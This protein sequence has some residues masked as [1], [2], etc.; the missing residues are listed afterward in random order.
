MNSSLPSLPLG[1]IAIVL[2]VLL[3]L[4]FRN[5]G[6]RDKDMPP[7][8]KTTLV[9][10]NALEFPTSFPHIKF[11]EWTR[12]YGDIFSLKIFDR[13]I[14]VVSSATA[15]KQILDIDGART[16]NRP[17]SKIAHRVTKG[18]SMFLENMENPVWKRGSQVI[19]NFLNRGSLEK[20]LRI[21]E[22]EISQ[23]MY[24]FLEDPKNFYRHVC[25]S[26][27]SAILTNIYGVRVAK[28][29]GSI[30]ETYFQGIKLFSE[31]LD[32]G[33]HPPVDLFW[34]LQYVPKRWAYWKRLADSTRA[35][36]DELYGSLFAQCELAVKQKNFT[37]CYMDSLI[38]N[39]AKS[40]MS[41][42]EII[43][44]GAV[45]MDGGVKT[46]ATFTHSLVLALINYPEFQRKAQE[47]IDTVVGPDRWPRLK[48]YENV[49]YIRAIVD[50]VIRFRT[51]APVAIPHVS[52]EEVRY[53]GYRIPKDSVI[54][55]NV[56]GIF[57]DP[58]FYDHPEE[59]RPERFLKTEFGTKPGVDMTGYRNNF[60]FGA[61]RRA[62]PGEAL[63]RQNMALTIM[64]FLWAFDFK[65]DDSGTGGY[66]L[67]TYERPG[68]ELAPKEFTC[69]VL[70][71]S[72]AKA[73]MIRNRMANVYGGAQE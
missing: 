53:K 69:D 27:A 25:R 2:L 3:F 9:L 52:T 1:G 38:S 11:L 6:T 14:I 43:G 22:D 63:A 42:D 23:C 71:R 18:W 26:T 29:E 24:N 64:N 60:T 12:Q 5:V 35:I 15:V 44:I 21:Q 65:K 45:L 57:H 62:C 58:D 16:G 20:H 70:P 56:H 19:R 33:T 13:T 31:S 54:F 51:S 73:E 47:E 61:G 30:A 66:D 49:P 36:R 37:G 67:D 28:Y 50:E 32:P 40:G 55:M 39:Q 34:P 17:R 68:I 59:F 72:V 7:G 4:K 8:P 48:D 41:R 46:T 10:G